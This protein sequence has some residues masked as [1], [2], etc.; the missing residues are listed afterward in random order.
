MKKFITAEDLKRLDVQTIRDSGV[1]N[2]T[3][4]HLMQLF[5]NSRK[6][7]TRFFLWCISTPLVSDTFPPWK[8]SPVCLCSFCLPRPGRAN[9]FVSLNPPSRPLSH[10][11]PG[12]DY[13]DNWKALLLSSAPRA[14]DSVL[15]LME[16]LQAIAGTNT[17][18]SLSRSILINYKL[19]S[20]ALT[21]QHGGTPPLQEVS[22]S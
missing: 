12:R 1:I 7:L 19:D 8:S 5:T 20:F 21:V 3:A 11:I 6:W 10:K 22:L 9:V 4:I 17:L 14:V 18:I 2:I 16:E 13:F 15:Q